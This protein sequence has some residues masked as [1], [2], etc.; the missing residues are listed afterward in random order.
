MN[1]TIREPTDQDLAKLAKVHV[2]VWQESYKDLIRSDYLDNLKLDIC[3][4][5][6]KEN[7]EK[8]FKM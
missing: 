4:K 3:E 5:Q 1:Y 2:K 7:L 6:W 8:N